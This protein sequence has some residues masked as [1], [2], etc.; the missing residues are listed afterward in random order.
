MISSPTCFMVGSYLTFRKSSVRLLGAIS[1][2]AERKAATPL[3]PGSRA[4]L[5]SIPCPFP[6]ASCPISPL[7]KSAFGTIFCCNQ[8]KYL[9]RIWIK[10]NFTNV[11]SFGIKIPTNLSPS[12]PGHPP[13]GPLHYASRRHSGG[14]RSHP[15]ESR[16]ALRGCSS[17]MGAAVCHHGIAQQSPI[18]SS[19][20]ILFI[21]G[22]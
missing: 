22:T 7:Q 6:R 21:C 3:V 19:H 13:L 12:K 9:N 8:L 4:T 14:N 1:M 18:V 17:K 11:I 20:F 10:M 5:S 15:L 2:P 16:E